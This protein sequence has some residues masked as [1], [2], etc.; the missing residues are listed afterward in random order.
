MSDKLSAT[1][2]HSNGAFNARTS[3][4]LWECEFA[5]ALKPS[6]L[7]AF[8]QLEKPF[9]VKA[10]SCL[11]DEMAFKRVALMHVKQNAESEARS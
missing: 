11:V 6:L 8:F 5:W 10:H 2:L 7:V 4:S 1:F 3:A 9:F